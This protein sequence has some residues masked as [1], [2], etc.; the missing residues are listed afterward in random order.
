MKTLPFAEVVILPDWT[1]VV[2][3]HRD[4]RGNTIITMSVRLPPKLFDSRFK[5]GFIILEDENVPHCP[6]TAK[7]SCLVVGQEPDFD[8]GFYIEHN[9]GV[10]MPIRAL[11]LP[12]DAEIFTKF[13]RQMSQRPEAV[14][15][16]AN[17]IVVNVPPD[18]NTY[19]TLGS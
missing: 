17:I 8:V 14:P 5:G 7:F 11:N 16:L 3:E 1:A 19:M 12:E 4:F 10:G 2:Y 18:K 9:H 6:S 15:Y 13:L